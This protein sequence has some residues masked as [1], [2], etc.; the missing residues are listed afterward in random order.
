[1]TSLP[2]A[3]VNDVT[4]DILHTGQDGWLFLTGGTNSV[5]KQYQT[6]GLPPGH[7]AYYAHL[8]EDRLRRCGELG[9]EYISV[10][11]PEKIAVYDHR[12]SG[13]EIDVS[14]SPS[15]QIERALLPLKSG[16]HHVDLLKLFRSR[17]D[18]AQLFL[19]TDSHWT[20]YGCYLAYQAL[21][22]RMTVEPRAELARLETRQVSA[23]SGDLGI[24]LDPPHEEPAETWSFG[25]TSER[26]YAN[27]L[28]ERFEALGALHA[29]GTAS[30]MVYRNHAP[31]IS[32]KRIIVFGDSFT[33]HVGTHG[34][35]R[36]IVFLT[37]T[38]SE[39]HFVW[40]NTIDYEYV[41]AVRPD[42]VLTEIAERFMIQLPMMEFRIADY[43]KSEIERKLG[44][45]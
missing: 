3:A 40:A 13:L 7:L 37:E 12:L 6:G 36:L 10:V 1:M 15:A 30:H 41:A 17:R 35:G 27:Q 2:Q 25:Q 9:S 19:K 23:F 11:V 45:T 32:P 43:E 21:C 38:F 29:S 33:S 16:H 8:H 26:V 34:V 24:K 18:E 28:V 4:E 22:H 20:F 42:Y 5:L 44:S 39:V 31:G 14:V